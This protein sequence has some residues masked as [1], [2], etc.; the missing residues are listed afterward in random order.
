MVPTPT[1]STTAAPTTKPSN[2]STAPTDTSSPAP[3]GHT[4]SNHHSLST[5]PDSTTGTKLSPSGV[6]AAGVQSPPS[7]APHPHQ[8]LIQSAPLVATAAT[9]PTPHP[10]AISAITTAAVTAPSTTPTAPPVRVTPLPGAV[11]TLARLVLAAAGM[12]PTNP[13]PANA[14]P[15][16]LFAAATKLENQYNPAPPAATPTVATADPNT[17]TVTTNALFTTA[18]TTSASPLTAAA[19]TPTSARTNVPTVNPVPTGESST[20]V[21]TGNLYPTS[22]TGTVSIAVTQQP[23]HGTVVV[24]NSGAYTYS[25]TSSFALAGGT[26][27]F[28]VAVSATNPNGKILPNSTIQA[29]VPVTVAPIDKPVAGTPTV[30][31]PNPLTGAVTGAA[32]FTDPAGRTL[33]YTAPTTSTGGGTVTVNTA[34]GAYTYTPTK[35]QRQAATTGSTDTFTVTAN[36]GHR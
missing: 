20:G 9:T 13:Q 32:V 23:A 12:D 34:T 31:T 25:P 3:T 15:L 24:N 7:P 35:T 18:A 29:V 14:L 4:P 22:P 36:D 5:G 6:T 16:V 19:S 2:P 21:V 11:D 27:S 30:G 8:T 1:P 17:G 28:T 10:P 33:T 26:D